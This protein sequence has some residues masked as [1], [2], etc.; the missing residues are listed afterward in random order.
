ML[1]IELRGPLL[2]TC[3]NPGAER[4]VFHPTT[5]TRLSASPALR[6]LP[7]VRLALGLPVAQSALSVII[8]SKVSQRRASNAITARIS[9]ASENTL[10][11]LPAGKTPCP[12]CLCECVANQGIRVASFSFAPVN[13]P[14][15]THTR[16]FSRPTINP[17]NVQPSNRITYAS[18]KTIRENDTSA[19]TSALGLSPKDVPPRSAGAAPETS[20]GWLAWE[21]RLHWGHR[22]DSS[23]QSTPVLNQDPDPGRR[24]PI[25]T[26]DKPSRPSLRDGGRSREGSLVDGGQKDG[27]GLGNRIRLSAFRSGDSWRQSKQ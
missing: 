7:D 20:S 22:E 1:L 24:T 6:D 2:E 16:S 9:S 25:A 5:E 10:I 26:D 21:S 27:A 19:D 23:T 18:L 17:L 3:R 11:P 14:S 15:P 8:P 12:G 13:N 4:S